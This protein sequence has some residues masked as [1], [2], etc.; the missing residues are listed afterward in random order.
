MKLVAVILSVYVLTL[1]AVSCSD[2]LA[3]ENSQSEIAV[4]AEIQDHPY[5]IDLCSPF[6]FCSC[7][8]T[9]PVSIENTIYYFVPVYDKNSN[10]YLENNY[11]N[12]VISVWRPPK[13]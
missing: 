11:P 10:P 8:Q 4:T 5:N 9:F 6:C 3:A 7:C 2:M 12:H 1:T 13:I